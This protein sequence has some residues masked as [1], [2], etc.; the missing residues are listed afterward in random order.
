MENFFYRVKEND[1]VKSLSLKFKIP[2]TIIIYQNRLTEEISN[3]DL[4]FLTKT[5][6]RIYTVELFDTL[7]IVAKKFC[8]SEEEILEKNKTPYLIYGE[9][10]II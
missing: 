5:N 6:D 10:I 2:S 8:V 4:L 1:T 9:I 3:G 7:E